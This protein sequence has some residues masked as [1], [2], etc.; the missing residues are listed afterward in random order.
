MIAVCD[1]PLT[2]NL[3]G[4]ASGKLTCPKQAGGYQD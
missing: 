3:V 1:T 2:A 4:F